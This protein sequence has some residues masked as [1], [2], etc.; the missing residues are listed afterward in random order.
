DLDVLLVEHEPLA[1]AVVEA[2][3]AAFGLQLGETQ[4]AHLGRALQRQLR[5]VLGEDLAVLNRDL[6]VLPGD[7]AKTRKEQVLDRRKINSHRSLLL[8]R[9]RSGRHWRASES[10]L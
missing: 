7:F 8:R 9:C 1:R 4:V 6:L 5:V 2:G 3:L 10:C